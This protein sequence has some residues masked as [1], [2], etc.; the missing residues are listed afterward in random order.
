MCRTFPHKH[1]GFVRWEN[2]TGEKVT[3]QQAPDQDVAETTPI[4]PV[5][6]T[7]N[8][9][10]I[11]LSFQ[12]TKSIFQLEW[13]RF[14]SKLEMNRM[15]NRMLLLIWKYVIIWVPVV[16]LWGL[17]TMEMT[18]KREKL[19]SIQAISSRTVLRWGYHCCLMLFFHFPPSAFPWSFWSM[20]RSAE[21]GRQL[22]CRQRLVRR[23][24]QNI[25]RG[26]WGQEAVQL[27]RGR[28]ATTGRDF[29]LHNRV[30]LPRDGWK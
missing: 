20:D 14:L 13:Q 15:L 23:L 22:V 30:Q 8:I 9:V 3:T 5:Y 16:K 25:D 12:P 26:L 6:S 11:S 27:Q 24:D 10:I 21:T 7:G 2:K 17:T 19:M 1:S 29:G 18:G 28:L 4:I